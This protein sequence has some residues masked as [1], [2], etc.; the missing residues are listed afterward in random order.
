MEA[1][2]IL[3]DDPDPLPQFIKVVIAQIAAI[4]ASTNETAAQYA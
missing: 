4:E 1:D 3:E 2:K